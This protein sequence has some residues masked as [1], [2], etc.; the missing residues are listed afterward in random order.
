MAAKL[1]I[2]PEAA[3]DI[4][5]HIPGT[6][7]SAPAWAKSSSIASMPACR[8]FAARLKCTKKS[9]KIIAVAWYGDFHMRSSMNMQMIP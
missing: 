9:M 7:A 8:Q 2:A 1:I 4:E 3:L 5:R 6:S